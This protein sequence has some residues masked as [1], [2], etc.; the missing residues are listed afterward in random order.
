[1][2]NVYQY[3]NK[4]T[5]Y[6]IVYFM[7]T[8]TKTMLIHYTKNDPNYEI[9]YTSIMHNF[10]TVGNVKSGSTTKTQNHTF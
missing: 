10:L 1:M 5:P 3:K 4:F 7:N 2:N 8:N 9:L 6:Y